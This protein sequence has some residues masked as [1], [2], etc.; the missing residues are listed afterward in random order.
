MSAQSAQWGCGQNE[1]ALVPPQT[2]VKL[3]GCRGG[4]CGKNWQK[5]LNQVFLPQRAQRGCSQNA[6][7]LIPP[8]TFVK[9][10]GSLGGL[11]GKSWQ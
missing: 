2:F 1:G 11:C 6:C 10:C 8:Q 7:A 9:L 3:C 5:F 4:L